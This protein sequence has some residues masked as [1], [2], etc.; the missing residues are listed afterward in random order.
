VNV[1]ACVPGM[2]VLR[3]TAANGTEKATAKFNK[4]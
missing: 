2:Y 3:V 1:A 4:Q